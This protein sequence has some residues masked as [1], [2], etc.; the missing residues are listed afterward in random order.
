[1]LRS[2]SA[3]L[4]CDHRISCRNCCLRRPVGRFPGARHDRAGHI[5]Q[6]PAGPPDDA[7]SRAAPARPE[8][9]CGTTV[10]VDVAQDLRT[11]IRQFL[12]VVM[13]DLQKVEIVGRVY[14][15]D[16]AETL[17]R[18]GRHRHALRRK[19]RDQVARPVRVFERVDDAPMHHVLL[20]LVRKLAVIEEQLH[21]VGVPLRSQRRAG[22]AVSTSPAQ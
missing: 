2:R 11:G 18:H 3:A 14:F 6:E 13:G 20:G 15:Q 12:E 16:R 22:I 10:G 9:I 21:G 7:G 5:A 4:A 1:M 17:I 19:R 8:I